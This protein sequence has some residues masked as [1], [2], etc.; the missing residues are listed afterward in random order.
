LPVLSFIVKIVY[1]DTNYQFS[2]SRGEFPTI[3]LV[4]IPNGEISR[5]FDYYIIQN[6][7]TYSYFS[8]R[9]DPYFTPVAIPNSLSSNIDI[10]AFSDRVF[11]GRGYSDVSSTHGKISYYDPT[12]LV[13]WWITSD[14]NKRVIRAVKSGNS[15]R[16]SNIILK[17][18][19]D[20]QGHSWLGYEDF[21]VNAMLP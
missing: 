6:F 3:T 17:E 14:D 4:C 8:E 18:R 10:K 19:K 7:K 16:F 15:V 13:L 20:S 5:L 1:S 2:L 21:R 9:E 12:R 11:L